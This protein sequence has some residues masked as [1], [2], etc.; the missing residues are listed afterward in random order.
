VEELRTGAFG[1]ELHQ[2]VDLEAAAR[3]IESFLT[4]LGHPPASDPQ[5][6]DTGKLVARAFHEQLLSGYRSD[7]AEIL[8][9]SVAAGSGDMVVLRGISVTCIC[10]HHLLPA[11]G[12]VHLGYLPG[13]RIVGLGA[14]SRLAQ[15]FSR[16]LTLQ[17]TLCEAIAGALSRELG[18]RGAACIAELHPT[19]MTARDDSTVH[20]EC[21]SVASFGLLRSD[22]ELRSEF[23]ALARREP[24]S[25]RE[26]RS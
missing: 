11:S 4:A 6:R 14:L 16:R 5:L 20:A 26:V 7:P 9:D 12:V 23:F 19:C 17:E 21:V 8:R 25:E 22:A 2:G 24:S 13:Q 18:A 15:C 1:L 10:P 3:A